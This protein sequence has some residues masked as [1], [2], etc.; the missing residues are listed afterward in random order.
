MSTSHS[1]SD[2]S[3]VPPEKSTVLLLLSDIGG[4]TW[5]MFL[6]ILG[7]GALGYWGD[8]TFQSLPW[9]TI[10]GL[11]IGVVCSVVLVKSQLKRI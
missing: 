5:R 8:V 4:T 9:L 3:P 6:P 7:V 1:T 10:I 11:V 2:K